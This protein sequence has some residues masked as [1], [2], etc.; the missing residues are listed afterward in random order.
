MG[1]KVP[2][3]LVWQPAA[4]CGTGGLK[5]FLWPCA[6]GEVCP[7]VPNKGMKLDFEPTGA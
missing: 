3:S 5:K 2:C 7:A 1:L 6:K 4:A